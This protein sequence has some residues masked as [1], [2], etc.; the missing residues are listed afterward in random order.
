[1]TGTSLVTIYT[2]DRVPITAGAKNAVGYSS[3]SFEFAATSE[4]DAINQAV[5]AR[6]W[7]DPRTNFRWAVRGSRVVLVG[8]PD[9]E[10]EQ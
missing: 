1:M 8:S 2:V 10:T 4:A 3:P 9:T 7:R 6:I 5:K